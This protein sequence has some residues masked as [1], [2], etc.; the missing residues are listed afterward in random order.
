MNFA[1]RDAHTSLLF[2][3]LQILKLPD[4]VTHNNI[5]LVHKVLNGNIPECFIN[6]FNEIEENIRYRTT[7]NPKSLCQSS[8]FTTAFSF[9]RRN[10]RQ[11][12]GLRRQKF[13]RREFVNSLYKK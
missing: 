10:C 8:E 7:R 13:C 3:K 4:I 11:D 6:Y 1:D 2:R 9:C 12:R 5:N